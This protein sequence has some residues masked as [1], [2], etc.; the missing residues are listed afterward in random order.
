MHW[1]EKWLLPSRCVIRDKPSEQLDLSSEL[2]ASWPVPE[3]VC[4]CCCEPCS[5]A[6][7]GSVCGTCLLNPPA[8]DR[9]Q[10]GFYFDAELVALLHAFKYGHQ[11]AYG[12]ILADLLSSRLEASNIDAL[13]AVPIHP[14]RRRERGF[15]QAEQIAMPLAKA[16]RIPLIRGAVKRVKNTPSQ[17]HL[18][19]SQRQRNLKRAFAVE[20]ER[21]SG[22]RRIALIDDVI[23][24]GATMQ[25]LAQA[26][27]AD[28]GIDYVESWAVAKT[29]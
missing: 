8:F 21:F 27:K 9:T 5:E 28:T 19:K 7:A 14:L 29:K 11:M 4:S 15:N 16:L 1:L 3:S 22:V 20:A 6:S 18:N 17:T 25:Q 12:R 23:T 24:T 26:I 10:V 13:V 2:V